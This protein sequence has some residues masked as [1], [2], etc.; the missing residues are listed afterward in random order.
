MVMH[1]LALPDSPIDC[2]VLCH[3]SPDTARYLK[4]QNPSS[5]HLASNDMA[6]GTKAVEELESIMGKRQKEEGIVF[7]CNVYPGAF[8]SGCHRL[9]VYIL[10][11]EKRLFMGLRLGQT[12]LMSRP[13]KDL[14]NRM[15]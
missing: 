1:L 6:F 12:W 5:W 11:A 9:Q 15:I 4:I 10:M 8:A 3:P 14:R 2:G 7:E 13:G